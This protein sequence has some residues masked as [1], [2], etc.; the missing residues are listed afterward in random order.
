MYFAV[1]PDNACNE[2]VSSDYELDISP[3]T[4]TFTTASRNPSTPNPGGAWY[5]ESF[6][7][8]TANNPLATVSRDWTVQSPIQLIT[9]LLNNAGDDMRGGAF[10]E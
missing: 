10:N 4:K 5:C 1:K 2:V 8:R 9:H 6:I 7:G 3:H